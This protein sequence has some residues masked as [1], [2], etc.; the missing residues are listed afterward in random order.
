MNPDLPR[1]QPFEISFAA[2]MA[3]VAL[4]KKEGK[5]PIIVPAREDE[6]GPKTYV[7]TKDPAIIERI[8]LGNNW[9]VG[10]DTPD[11]D[12]YVQYTYN[13]LNSLELAEHLLDPSKFQ[14][15]D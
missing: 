2:N 3:Q 11:E 6:I 1:A 4:Q 10:E 12:G 13:R 14:G 7:Y 9:H 15:E 8:R 5:D